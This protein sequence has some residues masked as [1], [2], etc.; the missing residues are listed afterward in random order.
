M[1]RLPDWVV[2]ATSPTEDELERLEQPLEPGLLEGCADVTAPSQAEVD[3]LVRRLRSAPSPS[4]RPWLRPLPALTAVAAVAL[5]ALLLWP[6]SYPPVGVPIE[7]ADGE[8]LELG[9]SIDLVGPATLVV[10]ARGRVELQQGRLTAE[11]DPLGKQRELAI[12]SGALT[13]VVVGTRFVVS[14]SPDRETV[15]VERGRVRVQTPMGESS[16]GAG[17]SLTWPEPVEMVNAQP[18]SERTPAEGPEPAPEPAPEPVA[19][20]TPAARRP[21]P[22]PEPDEPPEVAELMS[23]IEVAELG[24]PLDV[25]HFER[26]QKELKM[27]TAPITTLRLTE[28]FLSRHPDSAL[29]REATIIR[30][31]LLAQTAPPRDALSELDRWL[32]AHPEDPQFLALLE[33][34]ADTARD[35][36]RD[37]RGALP[38]YRVLA[39]RARGER[40]ARAQAFRGLCA[41]S[42]GLNEEA[43]DALTEALDND[44]LPEGLR[45]EVSEA[46]GTLERSG[47]VLPMRK[48]Q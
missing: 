19:L 24:P 18:A 12:D 34:R 38:G 43:R 6:A 40:R 45:F 26:I 20:A 46:L 33:L 4:P 27:N 14:R 21:E 32:A 39:T 3:G 7:L 13:T 31:E 30:L 47:S 2:D 28:T 11:V 5:L 10:V 16:L 35:G 23:R 1:S 25:L 44:F 36:L 41:F 37:C 29:A 22:A 15:A 17:E 9:P 8:L 48:A 42:E